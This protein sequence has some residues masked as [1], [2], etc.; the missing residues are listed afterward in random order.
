MYKCKILNYFINLIC[1]QIIILGILKAQADIVF[2]EGFRKLEANAGP[3]IHAPAFSTIMLDASR[4]IHSKG[5]L[6]RYEWLLP[7][8]LV[9]YDDYSYIDTDTVKTHD[10]LD[11]DIE[12][13]DRKSYN[14]LS[15][16]KNKL[17]WL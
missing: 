7:P 5:S 6:L 4:S 2:D 3:D 1:I 13:P 8:S 11:N 12:T 14:R 16:E 17:F 15:K 10:D 9:F